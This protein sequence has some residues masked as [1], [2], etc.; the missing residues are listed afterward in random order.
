MVALA[1]YKKSELID[2]VA[3][4]QAGQAFRVTDD[5]MDLH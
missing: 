5:G 2:G 3:Y 1:D 4:P